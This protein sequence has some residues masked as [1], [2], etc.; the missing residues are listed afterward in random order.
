MD[1]SEEIRLRRKVRAFILEGDSPDARLALEKEIRIAEGLRATRAL[2]KKRQAHA[3][4][5]RKI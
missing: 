3:R 2:G 1:K 5:K 4:K